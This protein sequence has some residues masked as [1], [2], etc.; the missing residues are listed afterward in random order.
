MI[1]LTRNRSVTVTSSNATTLRSRCQ[2][3]G[4]LNRETNATRCAI[5]LLDAYSPCLLLVLKILQSKRKL[6]LQPHPWQFVIAGSVSLGPVGGGFHRGTGQA[7]FSGWSAAIGSDQ[8]VLHA[9]VPVSPQRR[10]GG[11]RDWYGL[12][13][14][15]SGFQSFASQVPVLCSDA[16][17]R[18][19]WGAERRLNSDS[20]LRSRYC[21]YAD[22]RWHGM[23]FAS[24]CRISTV[25]RAVKALASRGVPQP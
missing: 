8:S 10:G 22:H 19:P 11:S 21:I 20:C 23:S 3:P 1:H 17:I 18:G 16:C 7:S 25:L 6:P 14:H 15:G 5:C 12:P 24:F 2:H 13:Q 9:L 4:P